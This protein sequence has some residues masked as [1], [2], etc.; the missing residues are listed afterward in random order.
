MD[1]NSPDRY[2]FT[3]KRTFTFG[4]KRSA[5]NGKSGDANKDVKSM[6]S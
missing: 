3:I 6:A 2:I 5:N 4:A 1:A